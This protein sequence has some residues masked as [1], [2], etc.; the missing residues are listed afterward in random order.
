MSEVKSNA[1]AGRRTANTGRKVTFVELFFDLVFVFAL[2][3]I[4]WSL[5][6]DL[7]WVGLFRATLVFWMI[8]WAWTQFAWALNPTNTANP[9]VRSI[10]LLATSIAFVMS[11]AVHDAFDSGAIWFVVPYVLVRSIGLGLYWWVSSEGGV[12]RSAIRMFASLSIFGMIAVIAGGLADPE[13]RLWLWLLA[14]AF[15]FVAGIVAGRYPGWHLNTSRFIERHGLIVIIALGE[16]LI[17]TG[18]GAVDHPRTYFLVALAVSAVIITCLLWWTYFG[19]FNEAMEERLAAMDPAESGGVASEAFSFLHFPLLGGVIGI[20]V[21]YETM[22]AHPHQPVYTPVFIA[23]AAG[24]FLFIA[25]T[26]ASWYRS[27]GIVLYARL[28]LLILTVGVLTLVR[29]QEPAYLI[30]VSIVGVLSINIYEHFNPPNNAN[31]N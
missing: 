6:H 30:I 13:L 22:V 4:T 26:A 16:S 10:V 23:Y 17:V 29:N 25:S 19:W 31:K 28:I 2:T 7:T 14:I 18:V 3:G 24:L 9:M 20:A 5:H 11:T 12:Q 8:W 15:D 21:G 1:F 27:T